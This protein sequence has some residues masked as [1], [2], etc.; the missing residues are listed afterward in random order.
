MNLPE[1][2]QTTGAISGL[3]CLVFVLLS[4]KR[5]LKNLIL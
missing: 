1:I 3:F 4:I 2:V 5:K